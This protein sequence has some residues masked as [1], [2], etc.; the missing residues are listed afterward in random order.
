MKIA[1]STGGNDLE[2]RVSPVFGRCQNFLMAEIENEEL[3][4]WELE[5]NPGR[6]QTRG[7]GS[8]ASQMLAEQ[9]V[10]A[11]ITG[12]VGS[13][14]IM[15]LDQLGI[16]VYESAGGTISENIDKFISGELKEINEPT[17][18]PGGQRFSS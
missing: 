17:A 4:G 12:K 13:T 1:L 8:A 6:D 5:D 9:S 10:D 2:G 11:V 3:A 14:S 7:A 15:A 18:G 16:N